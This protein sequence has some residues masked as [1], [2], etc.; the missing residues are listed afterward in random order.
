M[1]TAQTSEAINFGSQAAPSG[2]DIV[3][4]AMRGAAESKRG[5]GRPRKDSAAPSAADAKTVQPAN[6]T[7]STVTAEMVSTCVQSFLSTVDTV[8][9][10][11]IGR[12][13]VKL[14]GDKELANSLANEAK[15]QPDELKNISTLT[16]VVF[17]KYNMTR[18]APEV[19]LGL[20]LVGYGTRVMMVVRKLS[21]MEKKFNAAIPSIQE[22]PNN[23]AVRNG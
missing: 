18:Y 7:P 21:E 8:I 19:F 15:L 9:A 1:E 6:P 22:N 2:N 10:I 16:G 12:V 17:E 11:R 14:T 13:A 23:G 5:R 3:R 4:E 20:S